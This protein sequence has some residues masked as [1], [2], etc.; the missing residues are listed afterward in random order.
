VFSE[1]ASL[2]KYWFYGIICLNSGLFGIAFFVFSK[3][4]GYGILAGTIAALLKVWVFS[5]QITRIKKYRRNESRRSFFLRYLIDAVFMG[6]SAFFSVN[7]LIGC[8]FGSLSIRWVMMALS[9][10]SKKRG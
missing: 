1:T 3:E 7:A 5:E 10:Y 9:F 6:V 8:F 4:A 2:I